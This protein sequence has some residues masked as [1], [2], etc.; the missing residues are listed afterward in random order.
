VA[1]QKNLTRGQARTMETNA[2]KAVRATQRVRDLG[3]GF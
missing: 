1:K 2:L 3:S